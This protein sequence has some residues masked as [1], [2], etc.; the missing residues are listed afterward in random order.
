MKITAQTSPSP[1]MALQNTLNAQFQVRLAQQDETQVKTAPLT[2]TS[3]NTGL[4]VDV[5]A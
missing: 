3:R 5:K 1:L 4:K 2:S